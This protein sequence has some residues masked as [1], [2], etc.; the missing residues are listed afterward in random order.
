M[1]ARYVLTNDIPS[2]LGLGP[3]NIFFDNINKGYVLFDDR[4]T[5][6]YSNYDN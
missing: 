5:I 6:N 3:K 4:F 2:V 1:E